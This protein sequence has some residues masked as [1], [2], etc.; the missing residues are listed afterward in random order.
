MIIEPR[1]PW[2]LAAIGVVALVCFLLFGKQRQ[3]QKRATA[4]AGKGCQRFLR[5]VLLLVLAAAF[6]G[7]ALVASRLGS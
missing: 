6:I 4:G 7:G 3:A 5:A 2:V 1:N